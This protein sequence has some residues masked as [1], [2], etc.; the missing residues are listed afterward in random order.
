MEGKVQGN[1]RK[2]PKV[3]VKEC[4]AQH[5][6]T[7]LDILANPIEL[8]KEASEI[9]NTILLHEIRLLLMCKKK[10]YVEINF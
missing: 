2:D 1:L 10:L 4:K 6:S 9:Y 3:I 8:S 7:C 5:Y